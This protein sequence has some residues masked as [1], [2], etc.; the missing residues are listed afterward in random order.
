MLHHINTTEY[1]NYEDGKFSKSN[2]IGVFGDS[3]QKTNIDVEVYRYFL[4]A[5]RPESSDT[6]F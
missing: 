6:M 5:N 2:G 3:V 1:L 4:L